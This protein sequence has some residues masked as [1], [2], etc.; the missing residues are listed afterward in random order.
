MAMFIKVLAKFNK[1]MTSS[2]V[3]GEV[4]SSTNKHKGNDVFLL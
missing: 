3:S 1:I 2:L 4:V